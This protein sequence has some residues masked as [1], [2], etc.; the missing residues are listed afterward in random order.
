MKNKYIRFLMMAVTMV[1]ATSA[2]AVEITLP[3]GQKIDTANVIRAD[4][5]ESLGL[6]SVQT[7]VT[8]ASDKFA[9]VEKSFRIFYPGQSAPDYTEEDKVTTTAG[10]LLDNSQV[11]VFFN[12]EYYVVKT[13]TVKSGTPFKFAYSVVTQHGTPKAVRV[14]LPNGSTVDVDASVSDR[15]VNINYEFKEAGKYEFIVTGQAPDTQ[16][17]P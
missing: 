12:A 11:G 10:Q 5:A 2:S 15:R 9:N 3:N 4:Q 7:K 17:Q 8:I 1:I 13:V 16:P 14:K 6:K